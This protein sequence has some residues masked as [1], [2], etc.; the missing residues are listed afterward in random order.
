[1]ES[2][3]LKNSFRLIN[4][5]YSTEYNNR[6]SR[7]GSLFRQKTKF[8]NLDDGKDNYPFLCFNYIHHNPLKAG[9]VNK[10]EDWKYSSF[11]D[12]LGIRKGTLCNFDLAELLIDIQKDDFYKISCSVINEKMADNLY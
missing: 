2:Q 10:M 6:Y 3:V 5:G 4:S 8:K 9:L 12:Y 1:M 11:Q 7:T